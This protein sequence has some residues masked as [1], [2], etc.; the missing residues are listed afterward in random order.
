MRSKKLTL[1]M[2]EK[3]SRLARKVSRLSGKSISAL[4]KEFI[5]TQARKSGNLEISPDVSRWM[6]AVE[7]DRTYKALR[8]ELTADRLK[9]Y[10][11][12]R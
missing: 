8:D 11:T 6:G 5:H 10:E 7:S 9:K 2:E 4:V 12:V 1:Y 3:T